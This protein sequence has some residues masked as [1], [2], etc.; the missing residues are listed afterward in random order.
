MIF[1]C[2]IGTYLDLYLVGKGL[3]SFPK[4]PFPDIFS[5]NI[6]FTLIVLPVLVGVYL[7][8]CDKLTNLKKMVF[9][10]SISLMMTVIE[11][12][13]E[14]LGFFEHHDSWNHIFSTF[15]YTFYLNLHLLLLSLAAKAKT[16]IYLSRTIF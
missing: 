2:L 12:Q 14:V 10:L 9:I 15:G 6:S 1:S 16:L 5:I 4:R 3:Y 7:M 8:I 11:K 13:S